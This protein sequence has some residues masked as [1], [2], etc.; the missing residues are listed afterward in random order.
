[1]SR[2]RFRTVR[3]SHS[4]CG[5]GGA[6]VFECVDDSMPR[7][8]RRRLTLDDRD[9]RRRDRVQRERPEVEIEFSNPTSGHKSKKTNPTSGRKKKILPTTTSRRRTERKRTEDDETEQ[10]RDERVLL[11]RVVDRLGGLS[12]RPSEGRV[13]DP[14]KTPQMGPKLCWGPKSSNF[15]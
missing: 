12:G 9:D 13:S 5:C 1:M 2:G 15:K 10:R 11:D 6:H 3:N 4:R 8:E 14:P 7:I